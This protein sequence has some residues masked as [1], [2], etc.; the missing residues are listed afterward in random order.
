VQS[1]AERIQYICGLVFGEDKQTLILSIGICDCDNRFV[2]VSLDQVL[3]LLQEQFV[4]ASSVVGLGN[5][6]RIE[7]RQYRKEDFDGAE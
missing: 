2:L 3:G 6:T 7:S 1:R 4:S 5:W